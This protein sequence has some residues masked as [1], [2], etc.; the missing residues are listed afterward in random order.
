MRKHPV[1]I[2]AVLFVVS[3]AACVNNPNTNN[4]NQEE[5]ATV[6]GFDQVNDQL[7]R[8]Y[9]RFPSPD[10]MFHY[11]KKESLSFD[12]DLVIPVNQSRKF[13]DSKTQKIG[14][15]MYV[16][17]LA[18]ITLFERYKESM[19]YLRVIHTLSENVRISGAFDNQ[20]VERIESNIKNI[21][22]LKT[23]SNEAL[24]K[25]IDYL[26]SNDMEETFALIAMG[27]FV[28]VVYISVNLVED[29][30][31]ENTT[32][33]RI[34]EQKYVLRNL[35]EYVNNYTNNKSVLE[36]KQS[37]AP[38]VS[39]YEE[40]Q[41]VENKKTEVSVEDDGNLV[42]QGGS[43]LTL[44]AEQFN[45]LSALVTDLRNELLAKNKN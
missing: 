10:E 3:F 20:F 35:M 45:E 24:D 22:S 34:A 16:A 12:A 31:P 42:L 23:M 15:G 43:S 11:V 39:F 25:L 14:L 21:D 4:Q 19:D 9:Y 18:Y 38:I 26:V 37:L 28:E 30:S 41:P 6:T 2:I 33:Q 40:L 1:F 36:T 5:D 44:S 32:I 29:Y 8:V 13:I 7:K 27:G 17:D